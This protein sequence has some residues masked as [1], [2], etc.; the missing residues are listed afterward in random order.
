MSLA[1]MLQCSM[2]LVLLFNLFAF[3]IAEAAHNGVPRYTQASVRLANRPIDDVYVL[4]T[5]MFSQVVLSGGR[6]TVDGLLVGPFDED[7]WWELQYF[8]VGAVQDKFQESSK[9]QSP[10]NK[11]YARRLWHLIHL[12]KLRR[13]LFMPVITSPMAMTHSLFMGALQR[14]FDTTECTRAILQF[15]LKMMTLLAWH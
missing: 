1:T 8:T 15:G 11:R 7:N 3:R 9:G 14:T 2:L 4:V 12:K 10:L 5:S 13:R 6:S